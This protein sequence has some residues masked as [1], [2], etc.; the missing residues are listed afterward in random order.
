MKR[1]WMVGIVLSVA[2]TALGCDGTELGPVRLELVKVKPTDDVSDLA[3]V[4]AEAVDDRGRVIPDKYAAVRGR[5]EAQLE[6]LAVSGPVATPQLF[7]TER[8]RWAYWYNARVAW[9]IKLAELAGFARRIRPEAMQRSFPLDVRAFTL[10][11]IDEMLLAET[12]RS[13]DFRLA[14]CAP[15]TRVDY[16]PLP[17]VPFT[18]ANL[19]GKLN[20][21]LSRLILDEERL[22]FNVVWREVR[23]PRM[24]WAGRELVMREFV[25]ATGN[26]EATL[27]TAL[28]G[29]VNRPARRR[30][31]EALGYTVVAQK[32]RALLA[33]PGRKVFFPG[34]VGLVEL[35]GE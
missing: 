5:L 19:S 23:V 12:R 22:V 10:D 14:A 25:R 21:T 1:A 35:P 4:L 31:Q 27:T 7:P 13:G 33:V 24:L 11:G 29:R 8:H 6:K 34:K 9:S 28:V 26:T 20:E 16:A 18:A 2:L 15:G 17:K 30:L 32:P 3:A